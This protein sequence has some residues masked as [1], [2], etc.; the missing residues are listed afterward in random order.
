[1]R[2]IRKEDIN[3]LNDIVVELPPFQDLKSKDYIKEVLDIF[4]EELYI[5]QPKE[6][7]EA[8]GF[9]PN[10]KMQETS[11]SNYGIDNKYSRKLKGYIKKD[12][13]Y[14]LESLFQN[15]GSIEVFRIFADIFENIFRKINFYN[16]KVYKIPTSAGFALEYKLDPI[17]ITDPNQIITYPQVQIKK[18]KKYL[19]EL[20]NFRKFNEWPVPTNLVYIQLSIGEEIIN[21]LNTFLHGIQSFANTYLQGKLFKYKN[22]NGFIE[23]IHGSDLEMLIQFFQVREIKEANPDFEFDRDCIMVSYLP[24]DPDLAADPTHPNYQEHLKW[25]RDRISFMQN[26][27]IL[28]ND[29]QSANRANRKEMENIRRRWQTFLNLKNSQRVCYQSYDEFYNHVKGKY[30]I[31]VEDFE[32]FLSI[33]DMDSEPIFNFYIYMY[34]IFLSGVFANPEDPSLGLNENWVID[35]IDVLFGNLFI[36]ADFQHWYFNPVMDL[37]IRYFFPIEMEYLNDLI[38]KIFIK[39]KWNAI[40]YDGNQSFQPL[41]KNLDKCTK[42]IGLDKQVFDINLKDKITHEYIYDISGSMSIVP[43]LSSNLNANDVID[44]TPETSLRDFNK[45]NDTN[46]VTQFRI[47]NGNL[48]HFVR[49]NRC[50]K[51]RLTKEYLLEVL[52]NLDI[53]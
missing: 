27:Q 45:I 5:K 32:Y 42:L 52:N 33:I 12:L 53:K 16:V 41:S 2:E 31:I 29:Y 40:S 1:M 7:F 37:F 19:M 4:L 6:I 39:D 8:M 46:K 21:N 17:Y 44:L 43:K 18:T 49:I 47:R 11:L 13:S 20:E 35:Y 9:N 15:K 24:Y 22:K 28:L 10:E 51:V 48:Q 26:M 14:Q 3:N 34:S 30:P 50:F 36:K 38:P 25:T 23:D